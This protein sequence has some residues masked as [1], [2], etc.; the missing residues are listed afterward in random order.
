MKY[1]IISPF[2]IRDR[3]GNPTGK[4]TTVGDEVELTAKEGKRLISAN[5]VLKVEASMK[6]QTET[7]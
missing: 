5:C 7:R 1:K 3:K 6:R 2:S 4:H